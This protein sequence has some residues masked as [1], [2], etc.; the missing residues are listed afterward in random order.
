VF[1]PL[2]PEAAQR[3]AFFVSLHNRKTVARPRSI[4]NPVLSVVK[5]SSTLDPTAGSLPNLTAMRGT[6]APT[7][8]PTS[9]LRINV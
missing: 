5:V 6:R 4:K 7:I 8:A 3:A 9:K 2:S 1:P